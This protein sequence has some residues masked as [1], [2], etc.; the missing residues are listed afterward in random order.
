MK[1]SHFVPMMFLALALTLSAAFGP[2][3]AQTPTVED[4][5]WEIIRD[6][7]DAEDFKNYLK[8]YPN[9][10]YAA[11]ARRKLNGSPGPNGKRPAANPSEIRYL[12]DWST[13]IRKHLPRTVGVLQLQN[14]FSSCPQGCEETFPDTYLAIEATM[15]GYTSA[16]VPPEM[17]FKYVVDRFGGDYCR[18]DGKKQNLTVRFLIRDRNGKLAA[19]TGVGPSDCTSKTLYAPVVDWFLDGTAPKSAPPISKETN[20]R[21]LNGWAADVRLGLPQMLGPYKLTDAWSRCPNGCQES[22]TPEYLLLRFEAASTQRDTPIDD[23]KSSLMP[24]LLPV[25]CDS[26][27]VPRKTGLGVFFYNRGSGA[28]YNNF[29]VEPGDCPANTSVNTN[30]TDPK[31]PD[32]YR[33]VFVTSERYNGNFGGIAG[34]DRI[35]QTLASKAGLSGMFKAWI[36]DG[37][38]S[39]SSSFKR[40]D[41]PYVLTDGTQIAANWRELTD[42][43][44]DAP[45]NLDEY[46]RP[47]KVSVWTGTNENGTSGK[48]NC[49]GW[50]NDEYGNAGLEGTSNYKDDSWTYIGE[51]N[52]NQKLALFCFQQ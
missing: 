21:F 9:G 32:Q 35:C 50:T 11:E 12:N 42:S 24:Y 14:A 16:E 30:K 22:D 10:K 33:L 40:S 5:Y 45:I 6:S 7:S 34:A 43:S 37:R 25:Y 46:K 3:S 47:S 23:L 38:S 39:P 2:A 18:S 19:D 20:A 26:G 49:R 17:L 13:A 41:V 4:Q 51:Y 1:N 44:L 15:P 8:E 48:T 36:S 28:D 29:W 52:C 27:A 31:M